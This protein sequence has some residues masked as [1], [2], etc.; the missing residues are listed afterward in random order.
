MIAPSD[1]T[2]LVLAAGRSQRYGDDDKLLAPLHGRPLVAH[3]TET[4]SQMPFGRHLAVVSND[5]VGEICAGHGFETLR[6]AAGRPLGRS[7]AAGLDAIRHAGQVLVCLADMPFVTRD[8]IEALLSAAG[9]DTVVATGAQAYRGPPALF[10]LSA[11]ER[12]DSR[13]DEGA[14]PLLEGAVLVA[15]SPAITADMDTADDF[16]RFCR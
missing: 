9:G 12:L 13:L 11:R 15:A 5:A 7:L 10:P 8:H 6:V 2:A 3:I 16:A 4:L 1:C 14:R